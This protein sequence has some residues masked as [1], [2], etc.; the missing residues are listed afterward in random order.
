MQEV[1]EERLSEYEGLRRRLG[2]H[3]ESV[4]LARAKAGQTAMV[5]Y[6]ETEDP[7]R[8]ASVLAA[9]EEP[10][11]LWFK[12]RLLECDGRDPAPRRT[13]A[14][15]IF[16]YQDVVDDGHRAE[17]SGLSSEGGPKRS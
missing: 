2:I 7:E 11:D 9:S 4:W 10:F 16:A 8:I 15:L 17:N 5:V 1:V 14:E 12:E 13:A 6:L 3:N